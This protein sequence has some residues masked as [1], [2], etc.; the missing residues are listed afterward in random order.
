MIVDTPGAQTIKI[1]IVGPGYV[2]RSS[3]FD[4]QRL[5]NFYVEM[6]KGGKEPMALVGTPGLSIWADLGA[7]L[8]RGMHIF[9]GLVYVVQGGKLYSINNAGVKSSALGTL[10]SS[11]GRV[12][13]T[14]NGLSPTGG[15]QLAIADGT[16][17][18]IWN[19]KTSAWTQTTIPAT[20]VT[21][22]DGYF[23]CDIGGGQWQQ[24]ALYDGTTWSGLDKSTADAFPDNL[25]AVMNYSQNLLLFGEYTTEIWYDTGAGHPTFARI[26]GAMAMYGTAAKYSIARGDNSVFWLA[27][28]LNNDQ[29]ELI[30]VVRA[31]GYTPQIVTPTPIL[32]QWSKYTT[33]ADAF[34]YFYTSEGHTFY[35]ITFPTAN[36]T[37]AYD[38][39]TGFW[40][41]WSSYPLSGAYSV[42]RHISNAYAYFNGKH[43]VGDYQSG[44]IYQIDSA[45]YSENGNPI[46]SMR[47]FQHISDNMRNT[48]WHSLQIDGEIGVGDG[49]TVSNSTLAGI[50]NLGTQLF[51]DVTFGNG[52]GTVGQPGTSEPYVPNAVLEWS[53]DGG[54][55]WSNRHAMPMG[56]QGQ[57]SNRL[58]W[59]RLGKSRTRTYRL[60]ISDPV[61]RMITGG[62]AEV[63]MGYS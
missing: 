4:A 42:G 55:T 16:W 49:S 30:G 8:I 59:R 56:A 36:A 18:Y 6:D 29:G 34:A 10:A 51:G 39:S 24:S 58:I 46:V 27:Q 57:Y 33:V 54:H 26:Q 17:L 32:Y 43:L 2:G 45:L 38:T 37:W 44:K 25:L 62:I 11:S 35:V 61:K 23:I 63:T 7:A 40:H 21:F 9:N 52:A 48:F 28:Q 12:V 47:T 50:P 19:V 41:E 15:D 14:D 3:D 13:M 31:N 60:S 1:P 20:T 53:N 22:I 5:V